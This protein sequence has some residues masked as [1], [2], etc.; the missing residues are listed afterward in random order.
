VSIMMDIVAHELLE[1]VVPPQR[2]KAVLSCPIF[3]KTDSNDDDWELS[4][5]NT[6]G[7]CSLPTN[8]GFEKG[9]TGA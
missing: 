3:Q 5:A 8:E 6:V 4:T 1:L 9:S 7:G 2:Q